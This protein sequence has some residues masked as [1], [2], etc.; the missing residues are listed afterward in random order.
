MTFVD[1]LFM[2]A[3]TKDRLPNLHSFCYVKLTN[4]Q[5][6][7]KTLYSIS[8]STVR[9]FLLCQRA[10][11]A[12]LEAIAHRTQY[13]STWG[14]LAILGSASNPDMAIL[15]LYWCT[16]WFSNKDSK[17]YITFIICMFM[18][19]PFQGAVCMNMYLWTLLPE[20]L[21]GTD[22][23]TLLQTYNQIKHRSLWWLI[24]HGK[25]NDKRWALCIRHWINIQIAIETETE[26]Q[27]GYCYRSN[28]RWN[29]VFIEQKL[30]SIVASTWRT[31][32][33]R[34]Q[35]NVSVC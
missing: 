35:E 34:I 2:R 23:C 6:K 21:V 33:R 18:S 10:I 32:F 16:L 19:A 14:K 5:R 7:K 20:T 12:L 13:N 3:S 11:Q 25:Q 17:L 30:N 15:L 28:V 26:L 27:R 4:K 1:I 8:K 9:D 22:Y 24:K 31:L 29:R